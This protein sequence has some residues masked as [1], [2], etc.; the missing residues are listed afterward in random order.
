LVRGSPNKVG[1][2]ISGNSHGFLLSAGSL[3]NVGDWGMVIRKRGAL[4]IV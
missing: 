4:G 2:Y 1:N 3:L